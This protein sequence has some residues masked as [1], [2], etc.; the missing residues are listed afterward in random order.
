MTPIHVAIISASR[1]DNV[2]AMEEAVAPHRPYWYV[3]R[4]QVGSYLRA[5]QPGR[6]WGVAPTESLCQA[7]NLAIDHAQQEGLWCLQTDD[8]YVRA[9][10]LDE[11]GRL[12]RKPRPT[13][14]HDV[15]QAVIDA[16]LHHGAHYGGVAPTANAYFARRPVTTWGFVIGSFSVHSPTTPIRI[17]TDVE[18]KEDWDLTCAHL[19]RYGCVAR[20]DR[21]LVTYRHYTNR[22]GCQDYRD[23]RRE[24]EACERLIARYPSLLRRHGRRVNELALRRAPRG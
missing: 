11:P 9:L 13:T 10:W 20:V 15:A 14:F 16:C 12:D 23:A 4:E 19:E 24:A 6:S 17:S 2:R 21:A 8:D 1:P 18:L 5:I 3:P 7:R 22:G